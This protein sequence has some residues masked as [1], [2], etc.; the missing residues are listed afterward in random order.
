M[1]TECDTVPVHN[2]L[3]QY[4]NELTNYLI[5]KVCPLFKRLDYMK[6]KNWVL[7][8]KKTNN[9]IYDKN[10]MLIWSNGKIEVHVNIPYDNNTPSI[11]VSVYNNNSTHSIYDITIPLFDINSTQHNKLTGIP[12]RDLQTIIDMIEDTLVNIK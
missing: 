6:Y 9:N 5:D 7:R 3:E 10:V 4:N 2:T 11:N 1:A 12:H 8:L